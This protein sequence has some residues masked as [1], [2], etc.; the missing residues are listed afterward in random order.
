MDGYGCFTDSPPMW[1]EYTIKR[2]L[3]GQ[4]IQE[5]EIPIMSRICV[6]VR[7]AVRT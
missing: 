7:E 3:Q 5:S 4:R 2:L 6:R 1:F